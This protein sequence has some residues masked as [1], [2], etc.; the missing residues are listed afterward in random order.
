MEQE[1]DLGAPMNPCKGNCFMDSI[2]SFQLLEE[3]LSPQK[4]IGDKECGV[5]T[6]SRKFERFFGARSEKI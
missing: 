1:I 2:A 6:T 5:N 3:C 4:Q